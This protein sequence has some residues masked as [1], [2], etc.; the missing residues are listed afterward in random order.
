MADQ[1]VGREPP[2]VAPHAARVSLVLPPVTASVP[3]ARHF[4][5]RALPATC[6][7]DEV[8]LLVSELASN[9]VRHAGTDF[10]VTLQCD[11]SVVRIE[12]HDADPALPVASTPAVDAVT[13]RG[14]MIVDALAD[15]WG[16]EPTTTGKMVWFEL[17]CRSGDPRAG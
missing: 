14:L 15:R 6:W 4:V 8:T 2:G 17:A 3:A 1:V 10:T 13:G 7:A 9:A 16:V 5:D 11:G 12:A